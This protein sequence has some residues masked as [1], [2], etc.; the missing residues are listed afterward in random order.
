M[1]TTINPRL[2][3]MKTAAL[4]AL[5]L[6][7]AA[8]GAV[9]QK[10][11]ASARRLAVATSPEAACGIHPLSVH[12][13]S[14]GYLLYF[15]YAVVEQ[16]KARALFDKKVKPYLVDQA[17]GAGLKMPDDTKLGP[18]RASTRNP[19]ENGKQYYVLFSN[20]VRAVSKG[21]SVGVVM[22]D[23]NAGILAVD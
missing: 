1:A 23:C 13:A 21:S 10:R 12:T 17:T 20:P 22:G 14:A 6:A 16:Q 9:A 15:R 18:L 7:L 8:V 5:V 4:L 3:A 11:L 19:P 2:S